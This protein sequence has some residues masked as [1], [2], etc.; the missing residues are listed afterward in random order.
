M[1]KQR[2]ILLKSLL[3]QYKQSLQQSITSHVNSLGVVNLKTGKC[4]YFNIY[5]QWGSE[6][7]GGTVEVWQVIDRFGDGSDKFKLVFGAGHTSHSNGQINLFKSSGKNLGEMK[8]IK[9][10]SLKNMQS[11]IPKYG[12]TLLGYAYD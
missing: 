2:K 6:D 8:F 12:S 4:K 1:T 5:Q 9:Q 3:K 11:L 7:D 10:V